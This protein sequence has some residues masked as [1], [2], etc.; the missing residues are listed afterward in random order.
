VTLQVASEAVFE[1]PGP[2]EPGSTVMAHYPFTGLAIKIDGANF[3][4][5]GSV[6]RPEGTT[7]KLAAPPTSSL[8]PFMYWR[9]GDNV[10]LGNSLRNIPLTLLKNGKATAV[11]LGR[12]MESRPNPDNQPRPR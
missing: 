9:Y 8:G 2:G 10:S 11:Y 7:V 12:R 1:V 4:T 5:N 6:T 3:T